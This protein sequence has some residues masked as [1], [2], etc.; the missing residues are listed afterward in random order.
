MVLKA[1][2]LC[3]FLVWS[4][5][6]RHTKFSLIVSVDCF[7]HRLNQGYQDQISWR[8]W[9]GWVFPTHYDHRFGWDF[10]EPRRRKKNQIFHIKI[11]SKLVL[12]T[13]WWHQNKLKRY[14]IDQTYMLSLFTARML[15][16]FIVCY[17][18]VFPSYWRVSA[19]KEMR[20]FIAN[21]TSAL[22]KSLY[23]SCIG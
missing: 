17:Y 11:L 12:M 18:Y 2:M 21:E 23:M 16:Y 22:T 9:L 10:L 14:E 5:S 6:G 8:A 13:I 1:L 7:K 3:T 15:K 20:S 4:T 19:E